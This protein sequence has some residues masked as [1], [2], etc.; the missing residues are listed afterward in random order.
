M[1]LRAT[2]QNFKCFKDEASL[3]LTPSR[4]PSHPDH[5]L[6]TERDPGLRALRTAAIYGANAH[7]KTKLIDALGVLRAMIVSGYE[8]DE[9]VADFSFSLDK[10]FSQSPTILKVEFV[11]KDTLYEYGLVTGDNHIKEEWLYAKVNVKE[12][13]IFNRSTV[14]SASGKFKTTIKP[15]NTF[16]KNIEKSDGIFPR[17]LVNFIASGI[18]PSQP[19]LSEGVKRNIGFLE[20]PY[21]WFRDCLVII[22]AEAEFGGLHMYGKDNPDFITRLSNFLQESDIGI[23]HLKIEEE[24]FELSHNPDAFE[25]LQKRMS[26]MRDHK[27]DQDS[28]LVSKNSDGET[29]TLRQ[30]DDGKIYA[31]KMV[32]VHKTKDGLVSLSLNEESSGTNR[33]I[34]LAPIMLAIGERE[35]TFLIDEID[36]KLHPLLCISF[37]KEFLKTK[38]AGQLI[39]TTHNTHILR[40]DILRKDEIWFVDKNNSGESSLYSLHDFKI[41]SDLDFEKGYLVGRF[42]GI[43]DIS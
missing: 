5:I 9:A 7:G 39:F 38:S 42:G 29:V 6:E 3:Q 41:R 8:D 13:L 43:P 10:E 15:G 36:R 34:H 23:D 19:F 11:F 33:L 30:G 24:P 17:Q 40:E 26:S 2:I 31:M 14:R 21:T 32:A 1:L 22:G 16:L 37:L 27:E 25:D 4:D 35:K 20:D 12:V 18:H 28:I